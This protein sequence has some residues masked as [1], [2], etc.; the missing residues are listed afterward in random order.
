MV[1][2]SMAVLKS[3]FAFGKLAWERAA[4]LSANG[5][6]LVVRLPLEAQIINLKIN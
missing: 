1:L 4:P 3:K 6:Q 2:N 5:L